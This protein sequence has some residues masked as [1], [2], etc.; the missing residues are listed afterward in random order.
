MTT[1]PQPTPPPPATTRPRRSPG[2]H[3]RRRHRSIYRGR[4]RSSTSPSRSMTTAPPS[5]PCHRARVGTTTRR[6]TNPLTHPGRGLLASHRHRHRH[7]RGPT[8]ATA[9]VR[10]TR[11]FCRGKTLGMTGVLATSR[12][13]TAR[14]SQRRR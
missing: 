9:M 8:L 4:T 6:A 11:Q 10:M 3:P 12:T 2:N 13:R 14:R 5:R 1:T 7:R